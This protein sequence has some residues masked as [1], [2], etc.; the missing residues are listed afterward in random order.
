MIEAAE[1][2]LAILLEGNERFRTGASRQQHYNSDYLTPL[3]ESQKPIAAVI[4]CSDSRVSPEIVFDQGLGSIFVSRVPGNV[5]SDSAKWMLEIAVTE[6]KIPLVIVMGH[7]GCLAVGQLF[8]GQ[9]SG[10]GGMLR[11]M[12]QQAVYDA[13]ANPSDDPFREAVCENARAAARA[14][15]TDSWDVRRAIENG[16][17]EVVSAIYD[18]PSGLVTMLEG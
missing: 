3:A 15:R 1:K 14:L 6:L 16:Q 2:S 7:T 18:M 12:V 9:T 13:K 8:Q 10:P 17:T 4:A 11:L 5:A